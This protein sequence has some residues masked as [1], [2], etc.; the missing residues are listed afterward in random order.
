MNFA[1][2]KL[3]FDSGMIGIN[4]TDKT[5]SVIDI[6]NDNVVETIKL[7]ERRGYNY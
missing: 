5:V 6:M 4:S 1:A 2:G 7:D 3:Y